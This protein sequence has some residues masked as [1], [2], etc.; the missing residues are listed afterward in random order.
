MCCYTLAALPANPAV[1][2][3]ELHPGIVG[4]DDRV[5]VKDNDERWQAI[6]QVNIGGYRTRSI[7]TGTLIGPNLVL[8]AAH[9]VIDPVKK[10]PFRVKN[11][12]FAAGV[13]QDSSLGHATAACV[14]FPPGFHY[15]GEERLLPDLPFA[16]SSLRKSKGDLALIVLSQEIKGV[17]PIETA[18][19]VTIT[20]GMKVTHAAYPGDRRFILSLHA[21]CEVLNANADFIATDCDTHAGSSGG[22]LIL[23][24]ES[25]LKIIAVLSGGF[26][27]TASILF[28]CRIGPTCC[29]MGNVREPGHRCRIETKTTLSPIKQ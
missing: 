23:V 16:R 27:K 26:A 14:K 20:A 11:I 19:S 4:T 22:P 8:T 5:P 15:A 28:R 25:K 1:A 18:D 2:A 9:C 6:G 12:H 24:T 29:V 3:S 7:C 10:T 17:P 13:Y 21:G